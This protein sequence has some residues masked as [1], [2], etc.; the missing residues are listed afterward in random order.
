MS[1]VDS[2][3]VDFYD[4]ALNKRELTKKLK[5]HAS[6]LPKDYALT[7]LHSM[8]FTVPTHGKCSDLLSSLV[9]DMYENDLEKAKADPVYQYYEVVV[10]PDVK[11]HDASVLTVMHIE[12]AARQFPTAYCMQYLPQPSAITYTLVKIANNICW[13]ES[14]SDD[15]FRS[16]IGAVETRVFD[17]KLATKMMNISDGVIDMFN[18]PVLSI[19]FLAGKRGENLIAVDMNVAPNLSKTSVVEN[20]D[21]DELADDLERYINNM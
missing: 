10:I 16:N 15:K 19:D 12:E 14:K 8:G 7:L 4:A 6:D 18:L 17:S 11:V 13:Y 3:F 1:N 20:Y 2:S 21:V 9:R 5:R